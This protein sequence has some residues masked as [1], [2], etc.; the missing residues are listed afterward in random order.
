VEDA[1]G[2]AGQKV[3]RREQAGDGA[4]A[5]AGA[6]VQKVANVLELRNVVGPVPA[7]LLQQ[8]EHVLV[9]LARV[10]RVQR[11]E[12]VVHRAPGWKEEEWGEG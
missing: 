12:L 9:L 11:R 6:V 2:E 3:A 5:E 10:R 7:V 4:D 8:R 1:E